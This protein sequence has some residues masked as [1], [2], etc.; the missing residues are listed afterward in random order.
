[1]KEH[2]I[3]VNFD[4]C[5]CLLVWYSISFTPFCKVICCYKNVFIAI[6]GPRMSTAAKCIG[7][8]TLI[9]CSGPLDFEAGVFLAAQVLHHS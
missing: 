4:N 1:M 3:G 8:P 5:N 6:S 9:L 7:L 2:L